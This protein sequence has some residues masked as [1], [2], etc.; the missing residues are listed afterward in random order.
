MWLLNQHKA[1]PTPE[2]FTCV[3]RYRSLPES[4]RFAA[5]DRSDEDAPAGEPA[6]QLHD[7]MDARSALRALLTRCEAVA[8]IQNQSTLQS[9]LVT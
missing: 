2:K 7:D 6:N 3:S 5:L 4:T 1:K 8:C 9:L